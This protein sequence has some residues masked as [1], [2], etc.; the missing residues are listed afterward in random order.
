MPKPT[1]ANLPAAKRQA[2]IDLAI[3]E[4]AEQPY[5]V[6][7][8]SR[9]VERAGIAKGSLYQYF[10][11][12]QDLFLYLIDYAAQAQLA[13]LR[14]LAPPEPAPGFFA[15]LRWQMG[16]SA[17]VGAAAPRLVRLMAR[18]TSDD[19]PFHDEV[20]TRLQ[21]AGEDHLTQL[22]RQGMASGELN[23]ALDPPLVAMMIKSLTSDIGRLIA[24]RMG[25]SMAEVAADPA[26]LSGP[27]AEQIYDQLIAILRDGLAP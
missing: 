21:Q 18:A 22:V 4:F 15:L 2:I 13:L 3:E 14:E 1:F 5:A 17:Q 26:R 12:K 6:A 20:L 11:H 8:I 23:S 19:L 16:V 27:Q 7:S 9:I 10:E 25:L 24:Q